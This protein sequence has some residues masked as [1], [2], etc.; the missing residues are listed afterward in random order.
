MEQETSANGDNQGSESRE[1]H[2]RKEKE[3]LGFF[4]EISEDA[5]STVAHNQS[6]RGGSANGMCKVLYQTGCI[7]MEGLAASLG[8]RQKMAARGKWGNTAGQ[9]RN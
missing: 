7:G 2:L 1:S 3:N 6:N 9:S 5:L 8:A 4:T